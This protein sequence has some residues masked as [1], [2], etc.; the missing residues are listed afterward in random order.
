M[1][2][3]EILPPVIET[4]Q[5]LGRSIPIIGRI[6]VALGIAQGGNILTQEQ[7]QKAAQDRDTDRKTRIKRNARYVV[8]ASDAL[9]CVED[10]LIVSNGIATS[11]G[12]A[13]APLVGGKNI[14][15]APDILADEI[16]TCIENKVLSQKS[17]RASIVKKYSA[18]PALGHGHGRK[19]VVKP[20]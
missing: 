11:L 4:L 7:L 1:P 9:K 13:L 8:K 17:K 6:L 20:A 2:G 5:G 3:P 14:G 10:H 15:S 19:K 18:R 16:M 12:K